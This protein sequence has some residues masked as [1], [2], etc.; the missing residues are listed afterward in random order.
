MFSIFELS[1]EKNGRALRFLYAILF[2]EKRYLSN[3]A[4]NLVREKSINIYEE[5]NLA[6][7]SRSVISSESKPI[8]IRA[9]LPITVALPTAPLLQEQSH[10]VVTVQMDVKNQ[11]S[12]A[13]MT[14][15]RKR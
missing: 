15:V 11:A 2:G 5:K 7:A 13:S 14:K 12:D 4:R 3:I 1:F 8:N 10:L 9:P 6:S